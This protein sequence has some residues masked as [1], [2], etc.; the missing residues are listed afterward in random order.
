[1]FSIVEDAGT[2]NRN[3]GGSIVTVGGWTVIGVELTSSP[4]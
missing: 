3:G 4:R 2:L 1:M